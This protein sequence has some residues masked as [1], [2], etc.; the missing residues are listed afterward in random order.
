MIPTGYFLLI[1]L[2]LSLA[3]LVWVAFRYASLRR[4]LRDYNKVLRQA[5]DGKTSLLALPS[6]VKGLESLSNVV[7]ALVTSLNAQL[8]NV[9]SNRARLAAVLDQMTDGVLIASEEGRIQFANPAAIKLFGRGL[10]DRSVPEVLR[11]HQLIL[12]WQRCQELEEMQVETAEMTGRRHFLQLIVIP[13]QHAPGGSLLV[14]Q[15]LTRVRRLETIRR[16][17][18]SNLSHELRTPLASL[19]ALTETLQDG[20][21]A[22]PEAAPRFIGRIATE[23]DALTQMA[24]ELL[25][26]SR[27][28]SGQVRLERKPVA[29]QALLISAANRMRMQAE[30]AGL[31]LTVECAPDL[32]KVQADEPRIEQVLVNLIHNA[33]KFTP[34]GRDVVLSAEASPSIS[35]GSETEAGGSQ[36]RFA[37]RDRGVG[38]PADDVPRIFE[39]FYRVDK[40]RAG[41]GTGLGLS[42]SRHLVES[43][44]GLIWAESIEG[45]GSTFYFT[46]PNT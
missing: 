29:P 35:P 4:Q 40:S 46:L 14:V 45:E 38:I 20:A 43:H 2:L 27:I 1:A 19:R 36:V 33:V 37:V 44:G 5:A 31:S 22:D 30:R 42:I 21:L 32:P 18:I 13:D 25:D 24:Q 23:V 26:L 7:K 3:T 8:S 28:E 15:D 17:F 16:D 34:P 41:G 39:R 9:D 6:N 10:I 12:A 11:N